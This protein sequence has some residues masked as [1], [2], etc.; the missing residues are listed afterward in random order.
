M[1]FLDGCRNDK[2]IDD[3][4]V[5][6][7]KGGCEAEGCWVRVS[8]LEE[9][10]LKGVLL[11]E[12]NSDLGCHEGNEIEF[13]LQIMDKQVICCAFFDDE[14]CGEDLENGRALKLALERY[15]TFRTEQNIIFLV[16]VLAKCW[17]W[18]PCNAMIGKNDEEELKQMLEN[19]DDP[20]ELGGKTF[21]AKDEVRLVPDILQSGEEFFFPVF[22]EAE[23]MGEYGDHFSKVAKQMPEVIALAKNNDRKIEGIVVNAFSD[24]FVI[25]KELWEIILEAAEVNGGEN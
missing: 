8:G 12:P 25:N 14:L 23:D 7:M 22:A 21:T 6:L 4:L 11:N 5:Y 18:I 15:N 19:L 2:W 3:V 1:S 20:S 24:Q 16:N 17:V 13:S 9:H 10:S